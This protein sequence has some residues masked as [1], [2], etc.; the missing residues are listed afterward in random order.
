MEI[1]ESKF[2]VTFHLLLLFSV[3]EK[4]EIVSVANSYN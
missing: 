3:S 2:C 1:K 4:K